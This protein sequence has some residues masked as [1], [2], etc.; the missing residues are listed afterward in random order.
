MVAHLFYHVTISSTAE[1]VMKEKGVFFYILQSLHSLLELLPQVSTHYN[2]LYVYL[3]FVLKYYKE[4]QK[5]KRGYLKEGLYHC[6]PLLAY[7][8]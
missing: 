4:K 8:C 6:L 3:Y 5:K 1:G 2:F 7:C